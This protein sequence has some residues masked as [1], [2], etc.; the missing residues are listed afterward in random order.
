MPGV[1]AHDG[2]SNH[3]KLIDFR[4]SL[5][6]PLLRGAAALVEIPVGRLLAFN[7]INDVYADSMAREGRNYFESGLEALRVSY[8][9]SEED[10]ARIPR[11]GPVMAVANHPLGGVD[12]LI[13]GAVLTRVRPDVRLLVNYLLAQIEGLRPWIISVD[14][15]G[16]RNASRRNVKPL[17]E[18]L[19]WLNEGGVLATFPSGTVSHFNFRRRRITDPVWNENLAKLI[20]RGGATVVPMYFSGRNSSLFQVAGLV[21]SRLRTLLLPR[22]LVKSAGRQVEVRIGK[23]ISAHQLEKF[24]SDRDLMEHL[25]LKT[26]ILGRRRTARK[27]R[28]PREFY[29][30]VKQQEHDVPVAPGIPAEQLEAEIAKLPA[31][32]KL[33]ELNEYTV[34]YGTARQLPATLRELG[35]LRELTFR[36]VGEGTGRS[37]DLDGFD[38]HYRHLFMWNARA[39]EIVGAYRLGLA[40]Q[41]LQE[42]GPEGL[43]TTTLFDFKPG[44]LEDLPPAIEL[45]RSFICAQ[46]QKK[47][48]SLGLI[49]RGIGEFLVRHPRYRALFGPVSISKDYQSLSKDLMVQ[50]LK[51][52]NL[53][54]EFAGLVKAKNPPR[55]RAF[56]LIDRK[57]L[58]NA[59]RDIEDISALISE[60][61]TDHKGVPVL[62]RQYLKLNATILSFNVDKEFSHVIDGFMLVDLLRTDPRILKRYLGEEGSKQF[63]AHHKNTAAEVSA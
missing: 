32:Q 48:A 53:D 51:R 33:A 38:E 4:R 18:S 23:P 27:Q 63:L 2:F 6:N 60:V 19:R 10:L 14:P 56:S 46:Y 30:Y 59:V 52:T 22:E 29:P 34:Y 3:P 43:Y 39:R 49:W 58:G 13:L 26:Y 40:D 24:E 8:D 45:G 54:Q 28:K 12:G 17:K 7:R 37:T 11:E 50:F 31:S 25:R 15:F 36:A 47:H 41:I 44:F 57:L 5:R 21:H 62:L 16:G 35:R 9:I 55:A 20:R 61:E 1:S 42:R